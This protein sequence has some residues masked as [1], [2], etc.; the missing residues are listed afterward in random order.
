MPQYENILH[1]N[2]S[3][4]CT[5]LPRAFHKRRDAQHPLDRRL[6]RRQCV[7]RP[8]TS[9]R[10]GVEPPSEAYRNPPKLFLTSLE[11]YDNIRRLL[12]TPE[13]R[14]SPKCFANVGRPYRTV[15]PLRIRTRAVQG[16]LPDDP[17]MRI[18]WDLP[19]CRSPFVA[20]RSRR[21]LLTGDHDIGRSRSHCACGLQVLSV[22]NTV[23]AFS[24]ASSL[25]SLT[26]SRITER[27]K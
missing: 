27:C 7:S 20:A 17:W 24:G 14:Q 3:S 16:A 23:G 13:T 19:N 2:I 21:A 8:A 4:W 26:T 22:F 15:I 6:V 5:T 9:F 10:T 18:R 25:Y 1:L 11:A 12:S